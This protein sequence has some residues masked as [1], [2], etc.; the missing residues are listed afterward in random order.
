MG[1][2]VSKLKKAPAWEIPTDGAPP[3]QFVLGRHNVWLHVALAR[4]RFSLTVDW[5]GGDLGVSLWSRR[6]NTRRLAALTVPWDEPLGNVW[7]PTP[8]DA[9]DYDKEVNAHG[10]DP[11]L[12]V[13]AGTLQLRLY[14]PGI[15]PQGGVAHRPLIL[16]SALGGDGEVILSLW[17]ARLQVYAWTLYVHSKLLP[18]AARSKSA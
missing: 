3:L 18:G 5:R 11:T 14:V 16:W 10:C 6:G 12:K 7:V 13:P 4:R 2:S 15:S 8:G 17:S 1:G 9:I